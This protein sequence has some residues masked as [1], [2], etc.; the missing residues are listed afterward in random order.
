VDA[1]LMYLIVD[2]VA[3]LHL[4]DLKVKLHHFL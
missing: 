1:V 4:F 3:I 2:S